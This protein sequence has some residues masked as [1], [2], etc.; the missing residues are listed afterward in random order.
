MADSFDFLTKIGRDPAGLILALRTVQEL[1]GW[2]SD[3]AVDAVALHFGMDRADVAGAAAF[4]PSL[5]RTPPGRFNIAVCRGMACRRKQ[6]DDVVRWIT[7]CIGIKPGET[8]DDGMFSLT[9][10]GCLGRCAAAPAM[11]IN[12]RIWE[13]LDRDAVKTI[14]RRCCA[15]AGGN[16]G[17]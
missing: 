2:I 1:R 8:G 7:E 14:L 17:K 4:Y 6:A 16:D 15:E 3:E 10:T 11:K 12:D 9:W 5:R 13:R